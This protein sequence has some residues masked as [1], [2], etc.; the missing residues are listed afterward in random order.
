GQVVHRLDL[1]QP[2]VFLNH[3]GRKKYGQDGQS[4]GFLSIENLGQLDVA[5]EVG[6]EEVLAD[7]KD[8][9]S[10][11]VDGLQD[12]SPPVIAGLDLVVDPPDRDAALFQ[13]L[14]VHAGAVE[15]LNIGVAITDEDASFASRH[16]ASAFGLT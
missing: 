8:G 11:L 5:D 7:E 9:H 12:L 6:G 3:R 13:L 2:W 1:G 10:R 16:R 14:E 4:P 15:P